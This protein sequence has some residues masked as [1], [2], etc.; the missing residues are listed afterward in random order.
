[1]TIKNKT[2]AQE[3]LN[4]LM[5]QRREA[6]FS[7]AN[8][9]EIPEQQRNA[10]VREAAIQFPE[11][12]GECFPYW[13]GTQQE[14]NQVRRE[15]LKALKALA[16]EYPSIKSF[17]WSKDTL[18]AWIPQEWRGE[19]SFDEKEDILNVLATIDTIRDFSDGIIARLRDEKEHNIPE[20]ARL[21]RHF[22]SYK[23]L[24]EPFGSE[25]KLLVLRVITELSH[26]HIALFNRAVER[27]IAARP[28]ELAENYREAFKSLL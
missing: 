8:F 22:P 13:S 1:M 4:Y 16:K 7:Q 14:L 3:E 15:A 5:Q 2:I 28:A 18:H 21:V 17:D 9:L 20:L 19:H 12:A 25:D 11:W 10:A 24:S 23:S 27:Y 26:K 6:F